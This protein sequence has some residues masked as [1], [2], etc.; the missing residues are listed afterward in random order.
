MQ[1]LRFQPDEFADELTLMSS[2]KNASDE[3]NLKKRI[4]DNIRCLSDENNYLSLAVA[5]LAYEFA[6]E[7]YNAVLDE[8]TRRQKSQT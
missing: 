2:L 7:E 4:Y 5:R 1:Y 8:I 6:K 3:Y